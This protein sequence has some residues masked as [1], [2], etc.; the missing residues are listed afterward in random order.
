MV[1]RHPEAVGDAKR[2]HP[3]HAAAVRVR[4]TLERGARRGV[5]A[6]VELALAE[7]E[8]RPVVVA[9]LFGQRRPERL[10]GVVVFAG[11]V[12]REPA[13]QIRDRRGGRRGAV[14]GQERDREAEAQH[15]A[16]L[17]STYGVGLRA[18]G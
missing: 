9:D 16:I 11:P 17:L 4:R 14:R 3:G 5:V 18:R 2:R 6:V 1:S 7:Q 8:R 10:A 15:A 12:R 13:G